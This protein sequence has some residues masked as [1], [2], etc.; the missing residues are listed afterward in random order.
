[1]TIGKRRILFC[2]FVVLFACS[3]VVIILYANGYRY[4]AARGR[5]EKTGE[6]I[7]ETKPKG[8]AVFLN[9][10]PASVRI[11][12]FEQSG[13]H[14]PASIKY[15]PSG[16]YRLEVSKEE[17]FP[18]K[19][20]VTV[21][22]GRATLEERIV[23]LPMERSRTLDMPMPVLRMIRLNQNNI[24]LVSE[25]AIILFSE[26][27][28]KKTSLV[29]SAT[30]IELDSV[31]PSSRGTKILYRDGGKLFVLDATANEVPRVIREPSLPFSS[32]VWFTET[33]LLAL[34]NSTLVRINVENNVSTPLTLDSV[35]DTARD[36]QQVYVL[37]GTDPVRLSSIT[38]NGDA[39][40]IMQLQGAFSSFSFVHNYMVGIRDGAEYDI[41]VDTHNT[42]RPM[43]RIRHGRISWQSDDR[44]AVVSDY[45]AWLYERDGD[46]YR[47]T[48]ITR[49][50][51]P[52]AE[53]VFSRHLP[54]LFILS[55]G[56]IKAI[57]LISS[58][59]QNRYEV[60]SDGISSMLFSDDGEQLYFISNINTGSQL[61][62]MQLVK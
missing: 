62:I 38:P 7:I 43:A 14:T 28:Q 3:S 32:T 25:S 10:L 51:I 4:H 29:V 55:D 42:S 17:H 6:L 13:V 44:F 57:D 26:V 11:L 34:R 9:D 20:V 33:E 16:T 50:S 8:A 47:Q 21:Q 2:F 15:L 30:R 56:A 40:E 39:R 53:G 27:M 18:W 41:L 60:A 5:V 49:Q 23:L 59:M 36:D 48:L 54:Y 45:E 22:S 61:F 37:H 35:W 1:M 46:S 24:V 31:V 52:L 19:D 12:G 58:A